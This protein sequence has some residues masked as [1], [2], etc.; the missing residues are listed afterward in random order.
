MA[1]AEVQKTHFNGSTTGPIAVTY[2]S[3]TSGNTL[4]VVIVTNASGSNTFST[5]S[6]WNAGRNEA[7][8]AAFWKI[9]DGTETSTNFTYTGGTT[10][11][12]WAIELSGAHASAPFDSSGYST[13]TTQNSVATTTDATAAVNDEYG[14][15]MA[16]MNGTNGFGESASDSYTLLSSGVEDR[17]VAA[18]RTYTGNSGGSVTT[19][20]GWTTARTGRW[21][22][23]SIKP[24]AGAPAGPSPIPRVGVGRRAGN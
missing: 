11:R 14:V 13:F 17:D 9:S 22:I 7:E 2:S 18:S 5:P 19:T 21:L 24:A 23:A 20:L 6:G 3:P 1:I 15:S 10:T 12:C 8:A 4:V 16:G